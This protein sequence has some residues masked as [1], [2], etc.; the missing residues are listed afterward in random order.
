M[1]RCCSLLLCAASFV[2]PQNR[3]VAQTAAAPLNAAAEI[4]L[5][6]PLDYQVFQRQTMTSG[7][8]EIRGAVHTGADRAEARVTGTSVSGTLAGDW[9]RLKLDKPS[10]GFEASLDQPAGGFYQIE[11]RLLRHHKQIADITV[12]HV[13]IGEVFVIAGQSNSTNYGEIRQTTETGMVVVF[14]GERW[15]IANDPQPGVQDHSTKGSFIPAFGDALYRKYHVPIGVAA[16]GHGSTSVRQW[17]PAGTPVQVMP[18]MTKFIT[19]NS[20]GELVCDG[21][22]FNGMMDRIHQLGEHGFRAL[23]WHQGESDANQSPAHQISADQYHDMMA[24][25]IRASRKSAAWDFPWIT[26]E[27]TYH[28]PQDQ[29]SPEFE[30]AQ[31]SLWREGLA[32]EGPNTDTLG[33]EY[34]QN[35]G[36]GVHFSDAGLKAHGT[37]WAEAVERYIDSA[38]RDSK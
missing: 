19:H 7:S 10:G 13:G 29:G 28:T 22:L 36:K 21:T 9:V 27:A 3:I 11:I 26:A 8:V 4:S 15:Q 17:L 16:V 33:P 24:E 35:G 18:T 23:L 1:R 34:R 32:L 6:S 30:A 38:E 37:L 5:T 14:D 12:P 25:L 2:L 31:Q 20:D